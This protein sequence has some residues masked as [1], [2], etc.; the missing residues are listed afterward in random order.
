MV[1]RNKKL[2]SKE[3]GLT[4]PT[5]NSLVFC[6]AIINPNTYSV[7]IYVYNFH[8]SDSLYVT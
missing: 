4:S 3:V 2:C 1:N 6:T 8:R 5:R 7:H